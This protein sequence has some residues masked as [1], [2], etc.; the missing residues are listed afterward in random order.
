METIRL[1]W[2]AVQEIEKSEQELT[3]Q[4]VVKAAGVGS[5]IIEH[6]K[7]LV[8]YISSHEKDRK[9]FKVQL[10]WDAIDKI[11]ERLGRKPT[12]DQVAKESGLS[13]YFIKNNSEL[14]KHIV[15]TKKHK[16]PRKKGLKRKSSEA[17]ESERDRIWSAIKRLEDGTHGI[18]LGERAALLSKTNISKES[19]TTYHSIDK[20]ADVKAYIKKESYSKADMPKMIKKI[21]DLQRENKRLKAE[22]KNQSATLLLNYKIYILIDNGKI[23][24]DDVAIDKL[25]SMID[26][27]LAITKETNCIAWVYGSTYVPITHEVGIKIKKLVED[28]K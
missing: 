6:Y 8:K 19:N 13:P 21:D 14:M 15:P 10:A 23:E 16:N 1:L 18:Q 28:A 22:L 12:V 20:F 7:D 17:I 5:G 26:E 11:E 4:N 2:N 9:E 27:L 3:R 24:H 25:A